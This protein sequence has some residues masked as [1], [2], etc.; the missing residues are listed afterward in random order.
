MP[1]IKD[2]FVSYLSP[3]VASSWKAP[4]LLSKPCQTT[5]RLIGK[6][7]VAAGH[8]VL[9]AYQAD[10]LKDLQLGEGLSPDTVLEL[11]RAT[12]LVLR[13]TK[14]VAHAIGHSFAEMVA[15]ER[16]LWLNLSGLKKERDFLN[17]CCHLFGTAVGTVVPKVLGG[18]G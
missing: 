5:S 1:R 4:V 16:H 10:L 6:A 8:A 9:Q 12:D 7:Y 18:E 17:A 3:S 15:M 13:A 14:Q 11:R 2:S